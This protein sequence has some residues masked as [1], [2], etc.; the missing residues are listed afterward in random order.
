MRSSEQPFEFEDSY[1]HKANMIQKYYIRLESKFFIVL[2]ENLSPCQFIEY[3][4]IDRYLNTI[5]Q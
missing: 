2:I 1:S 4:I 5:S 3:I